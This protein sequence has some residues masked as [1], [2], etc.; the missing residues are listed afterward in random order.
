MDKHSEHIARLVDS[1]PVG[2]FMFRTMPD[3]ASRFD[4]MSPYCGTLIG[5]DHN[6]ALK[7]SGV[8]YRAVHPDDLDGF[9]KTSVGAIESGKGYSW[10]GRF[11][12]Q[13]ASFW[14]ET[15]S[16]PEVSRTILTI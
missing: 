7:D 5:I 16:W 9:V 6:D 12:K 11:I 1:I 8:V 14:L 10:R 2:I 4:Y 13:G 3:G 15:E